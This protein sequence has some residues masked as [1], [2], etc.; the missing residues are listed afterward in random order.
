M[1]LKVAWQGD[2]NRYSRLTSIV[3]ILQGSC[4][5]QMLEQKSRPMP[6]D[7]EPPYDLPDTSLSTQTVILNPQTEYIP[8]S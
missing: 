3:F 8:L 7:H 1:K 2:T 5:I 6:S 4:Y